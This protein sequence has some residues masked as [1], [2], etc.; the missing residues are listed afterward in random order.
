MLLASVHDGI[1]HVL[2]HGSLQDGAYH[3]GQPIESTVGSLEESHVGTGQPATTTA[4]CEAT[5]KTKPLNAVSI[6]LHHK[7]APRAAGFDML[8]QWYQIASR[9]CELL[10][11]VLM[12][13]VRWYHEMRGPSQALLWHLPRH[14]SADAQVNSPRVTWAGPRGSCS[15]P[16]SLRAS[17]ASCTQ[18]PH[19]DVRHSMKRCQAAHQN[20]FAPSLCRH[21]SFYTLYLIPSICLQLK[22]IGRP[23][24]SLWYPIFKPAC[25]RHSWPSL[26]HVWVQKLLCGRR[27]RQ[28]N[29]LAKYRRKVQIGHQIPHFCQFN[30]H[31]LATFTIFLPSVRIS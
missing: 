27:R 12:T 16:A 4:I 30:C 15:C 26:W 1:W 5:K 23:N 14:S 22:M 20:E 10:S 8:I 6:C 31:S 17:S 7:H 13:L 18:S 28:H 24:C 11:H 9:K 2:Q 21:T 19:K 25:H 29:T 3:K